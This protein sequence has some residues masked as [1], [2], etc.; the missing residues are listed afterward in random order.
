MNIRILSGREIDASLAER[1]RDMQRGEPALTS[2]YF[3]PQFAQAVATVRDD[4]FVAVIEDAGEMRG[5]FPFQR[6]GRTGVPLG[7]PLSDFH[8]LIAPD[9]LD[10]D[11]TELIRSC[12]LDDWTFDH[13][14]A[15]QRCFAAHHAAQAESPRMNLAEGYEAY[16]IERREAGSKRINKTGTLRRKLE[17]EIG[18]LR[19]EAHVDD[20]AVLRQVIEWKSAQCQATGTIDIFSFD[21]TQALVER[22]VGVQDADFA[23]MLSALYVNDE[24]I[25]AHMGMRSATVWHYWFPTYHDDYAKFSPGL[26][27]LLKM[28]EDAPTRGLTAIDLGKGDDFYKQRLANDAVMLAEGR[29][30]LP[31]LRTRLRRLGERTA[32]WARRSPIAAP[33]R[34]PGRAI[35]RMLKRRRFK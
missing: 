15:S 5:I 2:P 28:A 11:A 26:I 22:L 9:A 27:L 3:C 12:G 7:G 17:R 18:E 6:R 10:L 34:A 21:W 33:L 31:T 4:V 23:G 29:I 14:L 8:G 16:T 32:G 30:E 19:Y 24:L 13:L 25:A 35:R 20:P 1:W